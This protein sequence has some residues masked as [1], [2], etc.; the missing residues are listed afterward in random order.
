MITQLKFVGIPTRDQ[1]RALKFYTEQLGFEISTDQVFNEQQRWIELRIGNSATRV[2][3][4]RKATKTG[5]EPSSM[6][7][8]LAMTFRPLTGN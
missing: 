1:D 3:S 7:R 6:D 2:C 5:S 4:P 8:S